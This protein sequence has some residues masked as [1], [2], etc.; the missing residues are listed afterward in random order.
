MCGKGDKLMYFDQDLQV[1]L[2]NQGVAKE[3]IQ[4]RSRYFPHVIEPSAGADRGTLALICEAF[5]PDPSRPSGVVMKFN[6]RMAPIK[7]AVYP[8]VNKDGMPEVAEKLYRELRR[9]WVVDYDA[10]QSIGKRYARM[11]EAGTP[12]CFTI[13]GETLTAGTVTVRHRDSQQQERIAID[14]VSAFLKE[15]VGD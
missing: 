13:D 7:A 9:Q 5:T 1:Q 2:Q 12:Y 11:D 15:H 4:K 3:E 14:K 6:P 10:K 8:L